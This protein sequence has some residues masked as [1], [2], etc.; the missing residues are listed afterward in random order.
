MGAETVLF[1]WPHYSFILLFSPTLHSPNRPSHTFR[2]VFS[3]GVPIVLSS[4]TD[5]S[6]SEIIESII[7]QEKDWQDL[8]KQVAHPPT[9][10]HPLPH[11]SPVPHPKELVYLSN[12]ISDCH[13]MRVFSNPKYLN[14]LIS[15]VVLFFFLINFLFLK[16]SIN[17]ILKIFNFQDFLSIFTFF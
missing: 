13:P 17:L 7:R 11:N 15:L 14:M 10:W 9:P 12:C 1:T 8:G 4:S 2:L 5:G 6:T 3:T 16:I